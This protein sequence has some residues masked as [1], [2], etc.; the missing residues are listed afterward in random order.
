[1]RVSEFLAHLEAVRHTGHGWTALCPAHADKTPSLSVAEGDDGR[2]LIQCFAGC[3]A[4]AI[5]A[6]IG[7]TF[8]DLWPDREP[9]R[10]PRRPIRKPWRYDWRRTSR[11]V[12]NHADALF[13]RAESVLA[14]AQRLNISDW[15]EDELDAALGAVS[16]AYE[17]TKLVR[18]IEE[19][20]FGLRCRGLKQESQRRRHAV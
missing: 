9:R 1:M 20:A 12:L 6:V 3:T 16:R 14:V 19:A 7:L 10:R 11:D 2:I 5:L 17:D 4:K 18:L 13:L 15:T 8:A